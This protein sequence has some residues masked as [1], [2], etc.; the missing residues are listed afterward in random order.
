MKRIISMLVAIALV[1]SMA[2]S[3]FAATGTVEDPI[4]LT[5]DLLYE[6]DFSATVTVPAGTT[7]SFVAYRVGGMN[8]T[9]NDGEPVVCTTEGMMAPYAWTITNDGTEDAEYV[10]E[11]AYPVGTQA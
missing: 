10:I 8:M 4:D 11:V 7:H 5:S 3:V 6:G 2:P 9:I 1:L